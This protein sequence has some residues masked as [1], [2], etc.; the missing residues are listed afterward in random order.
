M[1][2]QCEAWGS[3]LTFNFSVF[4]IGFVPFHSETFYHFVLFMSLWTNT[5]II[6][7]CI[8]NT[9]LLLNVFASPFCILYNVSSFKWKWKKSEATSATY[10]HTQAVTGASVYLK[11]KPTKFQVLKLMFLLLIKCK[12]KFNYDF[13]NVGCFEWGTR[14]CSQLKK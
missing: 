9:H 2:I 7:M 5:Y 1:K 11:M 12:C 3:V 4:Q 13:R 6:Q 10:I 14:F 8:Q